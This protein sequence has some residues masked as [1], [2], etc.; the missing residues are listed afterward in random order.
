MGFELD[1]SIREDFLAEAG[2]IVEKLSEELVEIEQA[3]DDKDL[4]NSIFR[5]FHT[6]K[7]GAGF[8]NVGALVD[9]CHATEEAFDSLRKGELTLDAE[10]MDAVLQALDLIGDM[11]ASV[12]AGADPEPAPAVLTATIRGFIDRKPDAAAAAGPSEPPP[13][14][15]VVADMAPPS[16]G[17]DPPG[18]PSVDPIEAEFDQIVAQA[19]QQQQAEAAVTAVASS[20]SDEITDDEFEALL[21]QLQESGQAEHLAHAAAAKADAEPE[22]AE[23]APAEP[24]APV[25]SNVTPMPTAERPA[26]SGN[27]QAKPAAAESTVRVNVSRLDAVMNLVGELVLVRNRLTNLGSNLGNDELNKAVANL[28]LVT[29]DLQNGVMQTRMQPIRKVFSRFPRL[30][31]DA[32]R[33]L[34]KEIELTMS[35][36]DTDLDKNLVEALADPL[37]HLVRNSM[38]H[39]IEPPDERERAGKPRAGK[40]H[41]AAQQEGEHI[42]ITVRDDGRGMDPE[43]LKQKAVEKG[44][45]S[46]EAAEKLSR[47]DCFDLIF[48]AGFTTC[49]K[50]SDISGR[51]V[52]MDVVKTRIGSLNGNVEIESEI[53][54][55]TCVSV[56]V[57]L[58]LAI[59][60]TLMVRLAT[61]TYAF[62]LSQVIEVFSLAT[63]RVHQVSGRDVIMVRG[64]PLPVIFLSRLLERLDHDEGNAG[65]YVV[66]LQVGNSAV[67][68]VTDDVLGQE[69]VV[70]KPLGR[71]LQKVPGFAG[72]TITG[73]G[74]IALIF[75]VNGLMKRVRLAA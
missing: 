32:A 65:I 26:A 42:I 15:P 75:D 5:G 24:A 8:L 48:Q 19:R 1:D 59:L 6:I 4:L 67:G 30:A 13:E 49:E 27:G 45:I 40:V 33:S 53:G 61:N 14:S 43:K 44:V 23:P 16:E 25:E 58:T 10:I 35:G 7:G 22:T 63:E 17:A 60:P 41:L 46:A 57:P 69:E 21:D 55:G 51:G 34:N 36:E 2:E 31:R 37:V 29:A 11:L 50:V 68:F 66:V 18:D 20:D 72:A 47:N 71:I 12:A 62:P 56:R 38:D 9:L 3:P 39:G 54:K 73:D 74:H 64:K 70:I 28:D 52:G